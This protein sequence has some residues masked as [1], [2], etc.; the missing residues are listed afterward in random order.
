MLRGAGVRLPRH[1]SV[2]FAPVAYFKGADVVKEVENAPAD[3]VPSRATLSDPP[4][5][6]GACGHPPPLGEFFCCHP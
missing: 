5:V 2:A 6:Q 4:A 3:H 1:G